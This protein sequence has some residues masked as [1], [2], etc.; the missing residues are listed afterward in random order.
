VSLCY[1]AATAPHAAAPG[2]RLSRSER[3][4]RTT[5]LL[6]RIAECTDPAAAEE[7][8]D[9]VIVINRGV[10]E[11]LADRYRGRGVPPEDLR[12]VA[13]EGLVKA[14]RR[15][16]CSLDHDLL[17]FAVPTIRG[18]LQRYFRDLGWMV[19][20]PRRVQEIQWEVN[21]LIDRFTQRTGREP[22]RDELIDELGIDP[23]EYEEAMTAFGSFHPM[24]LDQPITT[25]SAMTRGDLLGDD[26]DH[27]H[28]AEAR[29][30]L[31]PI[32]RELSPRDRR[33][34][35]LRFFEQWT[36]QQIGE[37]IGVTQMQ[38][39]RIIGRILERLREQL[40]S[41]PP[42]EPCESEETLAR[43]A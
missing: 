17:T 12:Q 24:S 22:R 16:D 26:D 13:Y 11:A 38:V 30:V 18:E 20:P 25:D 43:S 7:L 39:S 2:T 23:D 9:E 21:R 29:V 3:S 6:R 14:V 34:L 37:E 40:D 41:A 32:V 33:I 36:Q 4:T 8:Y 31:G 35:Y 1:D 10:A 27:R 28:A 19:R 15:F 5:A 42:A